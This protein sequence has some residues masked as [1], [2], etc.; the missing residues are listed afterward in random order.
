M[1]LYILTSSQEESDL[2]RTYF[3]NFDKRQEI[4]YGRY[5]TGEVEIEF[6]PKPDFEVSMVFHTGSI[7]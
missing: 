5:D 4:F 7:G 2:E 3:F 1:K 6:D